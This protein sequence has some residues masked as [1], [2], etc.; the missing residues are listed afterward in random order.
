MNTAV[1]TGITGQDGAY[2]AELLLEKG[3]KVYGTYRRTSSVNFWRIEE[4]GIK[5]NSNLHLVEYD[6]TDLSSSIRLLQES[7]ATEVYN[8]AAQSF[9]GVSFDQPLTTA[10]ITGIGP[11][12]LLEAIRI[13]NPKIRFYQASTSEMFGKV[14]AIPQKEDTPFY[15]R[16]PYGVAKLYAHWMTINYRES[17]N[18]FASSG[19][20]FNH[21]SPLRGQEFVTRK[22]TDSVAKIK[23]GKLDVLELG[24]MDA[25]RDWGFAKE[26]VE[27]MWRMLQA[28]EPDT[29]VLA[30]NRTETVRDFVSMAFKA[31]GIEL[32]FEGKDDQEVAIDVATNKVVVKVNPKF[33]RPA[34]VELLIG[35][36]QRAKDILGWEPKTTLEELCAMMVE[37][38]LRRNKQGFSF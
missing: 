30:T 24:N 16:S 26:Y 29:F 37:E 7:K 15:P 10:E 14:Q 3:Y 5:N 25:K 13:V 34:E 12:N 21:E 19:I 1:I 11:V 2:L 35:N 32:R 18:I 38:D 9:V 6:L 20:L 23:L 28:D 17:Y 33:Y 8:L 31:A 27:G 4:L 22:I 36:P